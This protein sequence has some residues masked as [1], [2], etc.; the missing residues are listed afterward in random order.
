MYNALVLKPFF[1][2]KQKMKIKKNV[3]LALITFCV[4]LLF[5]VDP[6]DAT[7]A[8]SNVKDGAHV[9]TQEAI[10]KIDRL[11]NNELSSIKGHPQIAVI[12]T[13][14]ARNIDKFA[15]REFDK[16]HFGRKG[17]DNGILI[18]LSIQNHKMRI[19]TG[20]GTEKAITE[21]WIKTSA[22]NGQVTNLLRSKQYGS[23]VYLIADRVTNRLKTHQDQVLSPDQVKKIK[24]HNLIINIIVILI[25]VVIIAFIL[26]LLI[27]HI[28]NQTGTTKK[29]E[30]GAL[31]IGIFVAIFGIIKYL[32]KN[33]DDNDDDSDDG[34]ENI[35][36]YGGE[37]DDSGGDGSW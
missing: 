2:K 20:I 1:G 12:T 33:S 5:F 26:K 25:V 17:W 15:S 24:H 16:Y 27:N 6:V 11:N 19:Q 4:S 8:R 30:S 7:Q 35:G 32:F 10:S 3:L 18:V 31:I 13:K 29:L 34:D 22:M 37:S 9:M 28:Q 23:A 21:A 14:N 36:G